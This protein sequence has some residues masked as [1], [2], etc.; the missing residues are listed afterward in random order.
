MGEGADAPS[1]LPALDGLYTGDF[2]FPHNFETKFGAFLRKG[3]S[4]HPLF[5]TFLFFLIVSEVSNADF[6][7]AHE[8]ITF[9][10]KT[11]EIS[12]SFRIKLS[13]A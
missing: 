13:T 1:A 9:I 5:K 11:P 7:I 8:K 4:K 2:T 6:L 3:F 12:P 10:H